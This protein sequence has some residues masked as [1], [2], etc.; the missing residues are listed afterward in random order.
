M[1]LRVTITILVAALT[2]N[3]LRA[4]SLTFQVVRYIEDQ[5]YYPKDYVPVTLTLGSDGY[6]YWRAN[7]ISKASLKNILSKSIAPAKK[8]DG[9]NPVYLMIN[10]QKH[11]QKYPINAMLQAMDKIREAANDKLDTKVYFRYQSDWD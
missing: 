6:L 4:G 8:R 11:S 10:L 2:C 9:D 1:I 5:S 3:V 7:R